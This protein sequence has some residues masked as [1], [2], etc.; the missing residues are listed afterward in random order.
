[1]GHRRL[2]FARSAVAGAVVWIGLGT[3]AGAVELEALPAG[4]TERLPAEAEAQARTWAA[5]SQGAVVLAAS[6]E[7]RDDFAETLVVLDVEGA[8]RIPADQAGQTALL[9]RVVGP[10]LGSD[11]PPEDVELVTTSG[12]PPMLRGRWA[13]DEVTYLAALGSAGP[14]TA[15]VLMAVS[16]GEETLYTSVFAR[17]LDRVEGLGEPVEPFPLRAWR[18]GSFVGWA[19][20]TILAALFFVRRAEPTTSAL[21]IGR[22]V[23]GA[24]VF[25]ALLVAAIAY[26]MLGDA[27][28]TLALSGLSREWVVAETALFGLGAGIVA[29]VVAA[30][31]QGRVRPVQSAPEHGAFVARPGTPERP[32][33]PAD[34]P[35]PDGSTPRPSPAS[36]T[37]QAPQDPPSAGQLEGRSRLVDPTDPGS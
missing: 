24:C 10:I 22:R 25:A 33:P 15:I 27:S 5:R 26:V 34:A 35:R 20:W 9:Q 21:Q 17:T 7:A 6:P 19:A 32:R 29:M 30:V 23:G 18:I 3:P 14:R 4:W 2:L 16:P 13:I 12:P 28:S 37:P 11:V 1:M 31:R 36:A 8:V